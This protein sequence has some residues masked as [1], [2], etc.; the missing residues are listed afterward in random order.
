MVD[1][2]VRMSIIKSLSS[3]RGRGWQRRQS[4]ALAASE[5][6]VGFGVDQTLACLP[7]PYNETI[8]YTTVTKTIYQLISC[9]A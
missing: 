7:R 8:G 6:D 4:Y 2:M 5:M 1:L 9:P 3:W